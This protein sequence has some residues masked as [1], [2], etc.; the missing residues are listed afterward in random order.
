MLV[1]VADVEEE[2]V[3]IAA[4]AERDIG[5]LGLAVAGRVV[6]VVEARTAAVLLLLGDDVDDAGDRVGAVQRRRAIGQDLDAIDRAGRN[7]VEIDRG[8]DARGRGLADPTQSVDEDQGA[9]G[10]EVAQRHGSR[11]RADTGAVGIEAEVAGRIELGV[12]RG[13][14]DREALDHV[15]D[16]PEP[17]RRDVGRA[18]HLDRRLAFD[19][20]LLDARAGDLDRLEALGVIATFGLRKDRGSG[21]TDQSCSERRLHGPADS[22]NA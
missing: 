11:A 17:G 5:L 21:N 18:D 16:R 14:A 13:T 3:A 12:E 10:T 9:L 15:A 4:A 8:G 1:V 20:G 6:A 19:F 22:A 2:V 7:R